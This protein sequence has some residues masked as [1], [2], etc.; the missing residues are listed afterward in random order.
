MYKCYDEHNG[1]Q[2]GTEKPTFDGMFWKGDLNP[3]TKVE[4]ILIRK[5]RDHARLWKWKKGKGG[6]G[7]W[8]LFT[9]TRSR[10]KKGQKQE[11]R[12]QGLLKLMKEDKGC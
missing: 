12:D 5:G 8:V 2:L 4:G 3:S 7:E 1:W 10:I 11:M 9:L 6:S